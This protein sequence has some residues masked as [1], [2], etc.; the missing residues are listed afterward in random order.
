MIDGEVRNDGA[1]LK[2]WNSEFLSKDACPWPGPRPLGPSDYALLIGRNEDRRQFLNALKQH[3][4]VLLHGP[5][6]VGKTSLLQAGLVRDLQR[7]GFLVHTADKWGGSSGVA[8]R[9]FLASKL[10]LPEGGFEAL[11]AAAGRKAV[12]VLDQFEELVRYSP[13]AA[14]GVFNALLEINARLE[15]RVVVSFRSEYLHEFADLE[16]RA[17]NFSVTQ[18]ALGQIEEEHARNVVLSGNKA[19]P[20]VVDEATA[21]HIA[22]AWVRAR[23]LSG[24]SAAI[25]DPFNRVGLLHL[26]AL[27]YHL[28][29]DNGSTPL[30]IEVLKRIFGRDADDPGPIN[31]PRFT[32]ALKEAITWKLKHCDATSAIAVD[33]QPLVDYLLAD[34][35]RWMLSRMVPHLSSAG[36]KLIRGVQELAG[37]ALGVDDEALSDGLADKGVRLNDLQLQALVDTLLASASLGD[38]AAASESDDEASRTSTSDLLTATRAELAVAA[39][40]RLRFHGQPVVWSDRLVL[41]PNQF[42]TGVTSGPL[43]GMSPAAV[44]IE[45]LRRFALALV[46]LEMTSLVRIT[47]PMGSSTMVSLIHDGFGKALN[48]HVADA[49]KDPSGPLSAITAP[50]G[51]SFEW[52]DGPTRIGLERAAALDGS[53]SSLGYQP[54]VNLRWRGGWVMADFLQIVFINCDFRGTLFDGCRFFGVT[55]VN[56]LL[57]G[58]I[59]SDCV[60]SGNEEDAQDD[61]WTEKQPVFAVPVNDAV[62]NVYAAMR[63]VDLDEPRLLSDLP[64]A[65]AVPYRR[66]DSLRRDTVLQD[67]H[68]AHGGLIIQGGRISSLVVRSCTIEAGSRLSFRST[69]GSGLEL[70]EIIES[71]GLIE[72]VGSALRQINMSAQIGMTPTVRVIA[73][74]SFLSQVYVG[75]GLH[76]SVKVIDSTVIQ[77]WNGSPLDFTVEDSTYHG[78]VGVTVLSGTPAPAPAGK[79]HE[80]LGSVETLGRPAKDIADRFARMDYRRN[81]AGG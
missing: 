71:P 76:G 45:E 33:G 8:A 20:G 30:T 61:P 77:A 5:S 51:A 58:A 24:E 50:R 72:I 32:G 9:D 65:P 34:G 41:D 70:V 13:A 38:D 68:V 54:V 21:M 73:R 62:A 19:T 78:L 74:G 14:Q 36:Y 10:K 60:I 43:M 1:S 15:I 7:N 25:D 12:V 69:T 6:G 39:D 67:L 37:L 46:W 75:Q 17:I 80:E 4:L 3:R 52:S 59:F 57:D 66:S 2:T 53:T 16:S 42:Q 40:E 56:C 11:E 27:L 55:F 28:Y 18:L 35:S 29:F 79:Q 81:P 44:L 31:M 47:R 63:E 49:N 64:G 48:E 26:Q 22:D 23:S